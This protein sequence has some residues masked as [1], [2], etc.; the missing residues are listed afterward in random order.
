MWLSL[1]LESARNGSVVI[2]VR[3]LWRC[4]FEIQRCCISLL[5]VKW[6][7]PISNIPSTTTLCTAIN[8][9]TVDAFKALSGNYK[10]S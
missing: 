8:T 9:K 10:Y 7:Q 3:L 5:H 1:M 2:W 4:G 6:R